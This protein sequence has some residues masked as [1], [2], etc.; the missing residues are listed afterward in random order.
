[1]CYSCAR[2]RC[3]RALVLSSALGATLAFGFGCS[4]ANETEERLRSPDSA[5]QAIE[6]ETEAEADG[7]GFSANAQ[8]PTF[9]MLL[10]DLTLPRHPSDGGGRGWIVKP[11]PDSQGR[12]RVEAGSSAHFEVVFE[13]G[14]EG[15]AEG[16]ALFLQPQPF[17]D[18][19]E[20]QTEWP[21]APGYS[22]ARTDAQGLDLQPYAPRGSQLLVIPIEG[23][24]LEPGERITIEY[25]AGPLGARVDRYAERDTPLWLAVDG[26]GDGVRGQVRESPRLDIVPGAPQ[27]LVLTLPTTARPGATLEARIALLDATGSSY[28]GSDSGPVGRIEL[29]PSVGSGLEVP[30]YVDFTAAHD[31]VQGVR[32]RALEP[33][34]YRVAAQGVDALVGLATTSNPLIVREE[35]S[36]ISWGDLHGHSQLSDGTGT[37][38]DFYAYARQ[39]AGLDV[40]VLTDHDHWGMENLDER[41]D[42]WAQIKEATEQHHDPGH[43]VTLLGYEWTS[44]LQGHRHILYFTD[45]GEI[46]SSMD[47][48]YQTP[49]QLWAGLEGKEALTFAH[50]SAGGPVGTNWNYAPDP[51]FEPVTE[52]VSVHGSSEAPD[53]PTP[54]YDPIPGNFVRDVLDRGYVLGF[55]GSG[56][57]HDGHPGLVQRDPR[58]HV[59]G[60]A[61]L[62]SDAR[63]REGV[64]EAL[65]ARRSYATNGP[66]IFLQAHLDEQAMGSVAERGVADPPPSQVLSFEVVG[67]APLESIELIRGPRE[68]IVRIDPEGALAWRERRTL[69]ALGPA[70]YLYLR[71]V[72][73][74]EGAAWSSPFFGPRPEGPDP[75]A[76]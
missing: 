49:D 32:V 31:G 11:E 74:D 62:L 61:A 65:R 2:M 40:A 70:E 4:D 72:Q 59:G 22:L 51:R 36:P 46:L 54:I 23:R 43:F 37:P 19:D 7:P 13:A 64:L 6:S 17:W 1:M 66:R 57:S 69:P 28:L 47:P 34:T 52:I 45:D 38:H 44:W 41:P 58:S 55:V 14:P 26:D 16:G 56:D 15:I 63:T 5:A 53:S 68:S 75:D 50:H 30:R 60:L 24:A 39:V 33:G 73:E 27:Q 25:G 18:W 12:V 3:L 67:T 71:V 9:E 29:R 20:P 42:L 21:D 8:F 76:P 48:A 10:E 35:I